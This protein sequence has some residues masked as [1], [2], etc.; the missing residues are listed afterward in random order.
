MKKHNIKY[1]KNVLWLIPFV[2]SASNLVPLHKITHIRGYKVRKRC[3]ELAYGS[4]NYAD[5]K[6]A[7]QVKIY[8]LTKRQE[9][10]G[11]VI[12]IILDTLAHELAHVKTGFGHSPEHYR[13]TARINLKFSY[14]LEKYGIIDTSK[15]IKN[16]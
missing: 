7:I 4:T 2:E 11:S 14:I 6:Y 10:K 9:Y 1:T 12:S 15:R 3:Q 8:D 5:G 16:D 13:L